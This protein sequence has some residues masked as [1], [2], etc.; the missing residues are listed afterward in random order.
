MFTKFRYSI[1]PPTQITIHGYGMSQSFQQQPQQPGRVVFQGR[2]R[3]LGD[4]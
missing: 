3:R 2:G 4:R 1:F